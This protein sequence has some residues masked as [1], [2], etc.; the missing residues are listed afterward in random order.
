[1]KQV[2][3]SSGMPVGMGVRLPIQFRGVKLESNLRLGL[4]VDRLVMA[5]LKPVEKM[6]P[7]Y[8]AQLPACLRL[9][10]V[11]LGFFDQ[12]QCASTER[13]YKTNGSLNF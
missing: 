6:N 10:N 2:L 11:R 8:E 13:R 5:E 3:E 9:S 12:L 4:L 1:V 7:V